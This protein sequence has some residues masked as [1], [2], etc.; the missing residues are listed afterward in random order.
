[1]HDSRRADEIAAP[2]EHAE[3]DKLRRVGVD[4]IAQL[5]SPILNQLALATRGM[6]TNVRDAE[7]AAVTGILRMANRWSS[8]F[9]TMAAIRAGGRR[10]RGAGGDGGGVDGDKRNGPSMPRL[11]PGTETAGPCCEASFCRA[12]SPSARAEVLAV[13]HNNDD[14]AIRSACSSPALPPPARGTLQWR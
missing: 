7:P 3:R 14:L 11:M 6:S 1:V 8:M 13:H 12:S 9:R 10:G 2:F 5:G 4:D